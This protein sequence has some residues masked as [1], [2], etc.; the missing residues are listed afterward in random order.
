MPRT[1]ARRIVV[2]ASIAQACGDS[3]A[4]HPR[5]IACRDALLTIGSTELLVAFNSRLSSEWKDHW[6][7]FARK[8][9]ME[10]YGRKRVLKGLPDDHTATRA[11]ADRLVDCQREAILKDV[12]LVAAA[13][14]TDSRILST[15]DTVAALLAA[16]TMQVAELRGVHWI[17][18]EAAGCCDWISGGAPDDATRSLATRPHAA[19]RTE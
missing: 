15:D 4:T 14:A 11:A 17:N 10:M 2:D 7:T 16:L 19:I 5:A 6:S 3:S 9:L 12:H 13:V 8:W 1:R 18:P